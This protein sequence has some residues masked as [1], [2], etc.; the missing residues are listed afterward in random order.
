M[1]NVDN[2]KLLKQ[3]NKFTSRLHEEI[4]KGLTEIASKGATQARTK[5]NGRSSNG[6]WENTKAY[7]TSALDQGILA[8]KFYASWVEYGNGPT[9][10]RIYPVSAKF[11]HFWIDGKEIFAKSVSASQPHPF[12]QKAIDFINANGTTIMSKHIYNVLHYAYE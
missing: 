4:D 12:M 1:I 7:R 3:I 2:K 6:L 8:N 11:L 5:I 9:G 10:T